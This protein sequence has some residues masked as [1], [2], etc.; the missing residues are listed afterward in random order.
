ML[1]GEA[2][3]KTYSFADFEKIW[4]ITVF[5]GEKCAISHTCNNL[6]INW[7][8]FTSTERCDFCGSR[9]MQNSGRKPHS[10]TDKTSFITY[11]HRFKAFEHVFIV[12]EYVFIDYEQT[13][14]Y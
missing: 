12:Y 10:P 1:F 7:I 9:N 3:L 4:K 11:E 2:L 8:I 6:D 13:F 14:F 5:A